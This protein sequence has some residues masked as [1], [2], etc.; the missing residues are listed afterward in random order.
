MGNA[1]CRFHQHPQ[2]LGIRIC[3]IPHFTYTSKPDPEADICPLSQIPHCFPCLFDQLDT[4]IIIHG[5]LFIGHQDCQLIGHYRSYIAVKVFLQ[6][7]AYLLIMILHPDTASHCIGHMVALLLIPT[8]NCHHVGISAVYP[9]QCFIIFYILFKVLL[10]KDI[11]DQPAFNNG[12]YRFQLF[13]D[14]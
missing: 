7:R 13:L 5:F 4:L 6:D 8:Y 10:Q 11:G 3:H 1:P 2:C 12:N 14:Q 9:K